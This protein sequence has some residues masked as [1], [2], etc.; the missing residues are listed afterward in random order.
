MRVSVTNFRGI[1]R[2][3]IDLSRIALIAGSNAS[4]KSSM[5][6]A[7]GAALTGEVVPLDGLRKSD[8][9]MLVHSGAGKGS[10]VIEA[11]G[12]RIEVAYPRAQ[13]KTEGTPPAASVYAVGR[14][15]ILDLSAKEAAAVLLD[16]LQALPTASEIHKAARSIGLDE[17]LATQLVERISDLGW[18]GAHAAAKET[19]ARLKGQWEGVTGERYGSA[20]GESWLPEHWD[21]DLAGASEESL[22]AAVTQAREFLE[23]AIAATAVSDAEREHLRAR[24]A[25]QETVRQDICA[26][27][28]T[29]DKL[30]R[31]ADQKREALRSL[32]RPS[33]EEKTVPC[34]HCE[35]PVVIRGTNIVKPTVADS[36]ENRRRAEAIA[37]AEAAYND[38]VARK[39]QSE[40]RIASLKRDLVDAAQAAERLA[41]LPEQGE[42]VAD[43]EAAREGVAIAERRLAAFRARREASRLHAGIC[44]NQQVVA[45][46]APDG[47]RLRKLREAIGAFNKCLCGLSVSAGWGTVEVLD[48]LT[49]T[50]DG[51]PSV[52]LSESER[53]RTRVVLQVAMA[54]LDG[55]AAVVVDAA[56]ILDRTGRNGL[57]RMLSGIDKPSLVCMTLMKDAVPAAPD[58]LDAYWLEGGTVSAPIVAV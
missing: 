24:A 18:D 16:Y 43:I 52:L 22:Q 37:Q 12:G 29:L 33:A 55:S 26:E 31:E 54:M 4:G 35:K 53:F 58:M 5:A 40:A 9:G 14:R 21:T 39:G 48:D 42:N 56:D 13:L 3:D 7:V 23:A 44:V 47:L 51:K 10:I 46:L 11:D 6:Q 34:P 57:I 32:P 36:E 45:M 38:V 17:Q 2:A 25:R 41:S 8:A 30:A 50:Y 1:K 27:Q 20:K 19:G 28:A 49:I 15:S